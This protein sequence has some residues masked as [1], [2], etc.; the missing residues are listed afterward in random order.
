MVGILSRPKSVA[1]QGEGH[2]EPAPSFLVWLQQDPLILPDTRMPRDVDEAVELAPR[3]LLIELQR[4]GQ[5]DTVLFIGHA[6]LNAQGGR[7]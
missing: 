3:E 2:R 1:V 7:P 5:V 6:W 4:E